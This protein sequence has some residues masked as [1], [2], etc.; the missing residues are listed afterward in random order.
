MEGFFG[1]MMQMGERIVALYIRHL[2]W[3]GNTHGSPDVPVS[4][5]AF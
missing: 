3:T 4:S 1:P 5:E 2:T